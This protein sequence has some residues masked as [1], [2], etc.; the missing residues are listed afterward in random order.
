MVDSVEHL[1][2]VD[3]ALGHDHPEIRV[4][5][6]LDSS[7]RPLPGVHV[8]TRRSPVFTPKQAV[9]MTRIIMARKGFRLAGMMGYEGQIAGLGDK[10][11]KTLKDTVVRWIQRRSIA[12]IAKRRGAA[13]RAVRELVDLEFV[14]GGGTG[15]IESTGAEAVVTEIAAG[16]GLIGP[17]LF[18]EYTRFTPRP[19][20]LFAL[21]V[22]RRPSK[23]IATLYAG[24]YVASGPVGPA[25]LPSPYL[26][27]GLKL[28]AL[29][30]AGE[31]QTPVT[32]EAARDLR[33]G[34]RVWMRHVK[35]GELAERFTD[36]HIV[37]GERIERTV[38]TYRGEGRNFG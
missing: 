37:A 25:R 31:V 23:K 17:T 20:A 7:W 10:T 3:S 29:E 19:A 8:G 21:P 11:G 16:S 14:N 26:P 1:D 30:G 13:V 4:C 27:A 2:L 15:S 12:E 36:Y 33:L 28:I 32:G 18:D 34:D 9:A 6:E 24:G 38:P 22:V 5:L 35:A